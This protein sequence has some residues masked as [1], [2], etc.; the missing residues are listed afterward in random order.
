MNRIILV[1]STLQTVSKK[2][3]VGGSVETSALIIF[4]T[5]QRRV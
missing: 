2:L 4:L 5:M 1:E 3:E